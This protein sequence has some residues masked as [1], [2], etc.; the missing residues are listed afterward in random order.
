M[1]ICL[2]ISI[3][4]FALICG[5]AWCDETLDRGISAASGSP[6]FFGEAARIATPAG[7]SLRAGY[8]KRKHT[9]A[10]SAPGILDQPDTEYVLI[11]DVTAES[12]A[13]RIKANN[14]TFNLNG[15]TVT[16]DEKEGNS[17]AFGIHLLGWTHRD[18]A[19]YNG[20]IRQGRGKTAGNNG[21]GGNPVCGMSVT[22][23]EISGL[24]ISYESADT[25]GIIALG[26]NVRIHHNTVEDQ[27][28][29]ITNRHQ[30]VAAIEGRSS[31]G[32]MIYNNL[33][34]RTRH[35]GIRAGRNSQVYDND[36]TIDSWGTNSTGIA[37]DAGANHDNGGTAKIFNNRIVG[38]GMH[39]IGIWPGSDCQVFDNVVDVQ[40]TRRGSEYAETGAACLRIMWG[41][42]IQIYRN[43]FL[44]RAE[45]N[46][47]GQVFKS[48]GRAVWVGLPDKQLYVTFDN[49]E[50]TAVNSDG[51]AKAA[52]VA[53]VCNNAS[54][55]LVFRNNIISSNWSNVLLADSYGHG[56]GYARFI[57][58]RLVRKDNYPSYRTFRSQ[59]AS[60]PST[61]VFIGNRFEAGASPDSVDLEFDG[62]GVKE[63]AFGWH[64][65]TTVKREGRPVKNATVVIKDMTGTT[66]FEGKTNATG[67]VQA[68]VIAYLVTNQD[69]QG[70]GRIKSAVRPF[71]VSGRRVEKGPH[72]IIVE[73]GGKR[74]EQ[75]I[76]IG[77]DMT[78]LLEI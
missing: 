43:S 32:M 26:E 56:G 57:D 39:P 18:I 4:I 78:V 40:S 31:P 20:I 47:E 72:L 24:T 27:G 8:P 9:V 28:E 68:E 55:A 2:K 65:A 5:N 19:I 30:G 15:H 75:Q 70:E 64:L 46:F 33:I 62:T 22:G 21:V 34:K 48:W 53:I 66:V 1:K 38:R 13:F 49:N 58:N 42:N 10:L 69:V 25:H 6:S 11:N 52:A 37:G 44:V 60:I 59:Y 12:T 45:E 41:T 36:I 63:L 35:I 16:Y 29:Q 73:H 51:K 14:I 3:G 54:S 61:G 76:V 67:V 7:S 50:I 74:S 71:P 17:E 23:F 77:Q